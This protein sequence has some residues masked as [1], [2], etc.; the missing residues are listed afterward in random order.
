LSR[1]NH[2]K[3]IVNK[4]VRGWIVM[5]LHSRTYITLHLLFIYINYRK[6]SPTK[7]KHEEKKKFQWCDIILIINTMYSIQNIIQCIQCIWM[8]PIQNIIYLLSF[9]S[10]IHLLERFDYD[11]SIIIIYYTRDIAIIMKY[12]L[13]DNNIN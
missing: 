6:N 11:Y 1:F 5:I 8:Y 9:G 13:P 10:F 4:I 2:F 12:E 7:Q 3:L